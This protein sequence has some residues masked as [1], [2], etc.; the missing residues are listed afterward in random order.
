MYIFCFQKKKKPTKIHL[1][2]RGLDVCNKKEKEHEA[3]DR[4]FKFTEITSAKI[5]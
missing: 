1:M 4:F 5:F 2:Q 3:S